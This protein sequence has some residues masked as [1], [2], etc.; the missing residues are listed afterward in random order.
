MI[1][2]IP[3]QQ[4]G[5]SPDRDIGRAVTAAILFASDRATTWLSRNR[6]STALG[7]CV[8]LLVAAGAWVWPARAQQVGAAPPKASR[9]IKVEKPLVKL[10]DE[11]V[12]SVERPGILASITVREGDEVRQG[13]NLAALKDD[14]ARAALAVAE[15][16]AS[17]DVD[18]RYAQKAAEVAQAEYQKTVETNRRSPGAIPGLEVERARLA[19]DKTALEI[20]KARHTRSVNLLKRDEAAVQLETYRVDAPFDGF[21]TRVHLSRGASVKQGDPL[22]ELVSTRKV[23]VEGHISLADALVVR[24]GLKVAVQ[25]EGAEREKTSYTGKL[26]FVDVKSTPASQQVRVWAEVENADNGLRAWTT[27]TMTILPEKAE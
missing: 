3:M 19:A 24:P 4:P 27:P 1:S 25:I 26:V 21:V 8:L 2:E 7:L 6:R 11:V 14:V 17:S 12:L 15:E 16:E 5:C 22:I 23:R 10:I 13:Q 18:I 20:E 9:P